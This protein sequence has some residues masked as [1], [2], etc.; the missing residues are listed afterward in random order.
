MFPRSLSDRVETLIDELIEEGGLDSASLAS[1]L[2]AAQDSVQHGYC[3]ELSR[4]VWLASNA[5]KVNDLVPPA[6]SQG[7]G[8]GSGSGSGSGAGSG[9]LDCGTIGGAPT[10]GC[11]EETRGARCPE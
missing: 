9:I 5:L 1:I 8:S 2:V 3:P 11:F 10:D 6:A 4:Q 7:P